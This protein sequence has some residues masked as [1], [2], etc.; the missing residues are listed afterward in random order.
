MTF[1]TS[2]AKAEPM[3]LRRAHRLTIRSVVLGSGL[4]GAVLHDQPL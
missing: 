2:P 3:Q 1:T 4:A